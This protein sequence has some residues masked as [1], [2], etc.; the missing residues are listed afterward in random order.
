MHSLKVMCLMNNLF[1][2][3][4]LRKG[5][6]FITHVQFYM[7]MIRVTICRSLDFFFADSYLLCPLSLL[8]VNVHILEKHESRAAESR[9]STSVLV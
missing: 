5:L 3:Q 9:V 8:K 7:F 6:G 1:D 2:S 4:L